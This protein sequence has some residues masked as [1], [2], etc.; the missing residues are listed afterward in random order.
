MGN[1]LGVLQQ[2]FTNDVSETDARVIVRFLSAKYQLEDTAMPQSGSILL[3]EFLLDFWDWGT[4]QY[5]AERRRKRHGIHK[6]YVARK[7]GA[8]VNYWN[9]Y[10]RSDLLLYDLT[11]Q[12][13]KEFINSLETRGPV[14]AQGKNDVIRSGIKAVKWAYLE[15]F[16]PKDITQGLTFYSDEKSRPVIFSKGVVHKLFSVRWKHSK[17]ELASLL[18]MVT[19]MRSGEVVGLRQ[20][21]IKDTYLEVNHSWNLADKLKLTKNDE[22][23]I[24]FIP[25]PGLMKAI[26]KLA[27][28]NPHTTD[29]T[30]YIFWGLSPVNPMDPKIFLREMRKELKKRKVEE[31]IIKTARFHN[32]RHYFATLMKRQ[33]KVQDNLL[34]QLTGHKTLSM[35]EYYY[36]HKLAEDEQL[37]RKVSRTVFRKFLPRGSK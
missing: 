22:R 15:G 3:S 28:S 8:I 27:Y 34:Q 5:I 18:A 9:T 26:K 30:G 6:R 13:I 35:L 11:R 37:I 16:I 25:F 17:A 2:I 33:G 19:G 20:C 12:D 21:D 32:W 1:E 23:R 29:G 14:T 10:F 7:L 36:D 24:V 31:S 4:S